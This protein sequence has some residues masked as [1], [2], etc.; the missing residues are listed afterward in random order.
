MGGG[1]LTSW[2]SYQYVEGWSKTKPPEKCLSCPVALNEC[3]FSVPTNQTIDWQLV[4]GASI[5][6]VG[7]GLAGL[8]PGP[9]LFHA[10]LGNVDVVTRWLPAFI[11]GASVAEWI[12]TGATKKTKEL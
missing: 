11:A 4:G 12:K 5:F 9:A 6:G 8:C 3:G 7:W 10:C 2:L 1:V